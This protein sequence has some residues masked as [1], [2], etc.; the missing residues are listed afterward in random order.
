MNNFPSIVEFTQQFTQ[1]I[2][3]KSPIPCP[4]V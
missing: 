2:F 1:I 4:Q 3:S